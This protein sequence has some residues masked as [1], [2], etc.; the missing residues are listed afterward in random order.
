MREQRM[1][2][3]FHLRISIY[4][5]Y[6]SLFYL[7]HV[8]SSKLRFHDSFLHACNTQVNTLQRV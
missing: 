2:E 4:K 6:R 7:V 1:K 8:C 5:K 3:D